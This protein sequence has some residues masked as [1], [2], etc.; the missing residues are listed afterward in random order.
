MPRRAPKV[1][2]PPE[3]DIPDDVMEALG[4]AVERFPVGEPSRRSSETDSEDGN[5]SLAE[6]SAELVPLADTLRATIADIALI[7]VARAT[8]AQRTDLVDLRQRLDRARADL[9]TWVD[10]IDIS[11]RRAAIETGAKEFALEDG[12]V[13][14]EQPRGEWVVNV[15][16]LRDE[17]KAFVAH[18]VLTQEEFDGIFTNEVK[19]KAD[20]GRLN[21]LAAKRGEELAE[22]I[23]RNRA[24]KAGDPAGAKVRIQRARKEDA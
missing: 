16:A 7:P 13:T 21:S 15:P 9:S 5:R 11:F 10:A 17:I 18:G 2:S 19:I 12:V 20:N 24:W 23:A 3:P 22:A 1:V 14:I 8:P 6:V 4:V